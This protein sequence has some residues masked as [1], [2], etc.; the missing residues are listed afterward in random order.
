[1]NIYIKHPT[2]PLIAFDLSVQDSLLQMTVG[3]LLKEIGRMMSFVRNGG[4]NIDI[5]NF[6]RLRNEIT[7]EYMDADL[8]ISKLNTNDKFTIAFGGKVT[9]DLD[10][11][12]AYAEQLNQEAED[13]LDYQVIK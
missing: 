5:S 2:N 9:N 13:V 4:K 7:N 10:Q 12:N 8:P 6:W 3:S 1:M 11:I